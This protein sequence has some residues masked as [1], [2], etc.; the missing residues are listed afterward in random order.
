MPAGAEHDVFVYIVA[1]LTAV[2]SDVRIN[3]LM[4]S[5]STTMA[6]NFG[7][8]DDWIELYNNGTSSVDLSGWYF[9]DNPAN[10]NKWQIPQ[11][12]SIAQG[13]YMIFWADEDSSQGWNHCNF[14]LS[15]SGEMLWLLDSNLAIRDS[16]T[17]GVMTTDLGYARVPNGTGPFIEQA[18]T[19]SANNNSVGIEEPGAMVNVTL[20]PNPAGDRVKVILSNPSHSLQDPLVVTNM[21]G[22]R[23]FECRQQPTVELD[24]HNWSP[25]VY[26]VQAGNIARKLMVVH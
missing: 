2:S 4:A 7:E 5:N 26:Q 10:L 14:K 22:Q 23:V 15:A 20:Y 25:G 13:D 16:L 24:V 12:T 8:F 9:T 6:D 17:F 11:G 18:P 1:P 19:F 21:L 3:E